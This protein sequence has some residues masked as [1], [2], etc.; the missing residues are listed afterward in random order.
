MQIELVRLVKG[1]PDI[2]ELIRIEH[3]PSVSR[4]VHSADN[5]FDYVTETE[6]VYYHKIMADGVTVGGIQGDINGDIIYLGVYVSERYRR[7]GIMEES[8]RKYFS[9]IPRCVNTI[10]VSIE[11]TNIPSLQLFR[12]LGFEAV[13]QEQVLIIFRFRL[14]EQNQI[15]TV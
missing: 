15:G 1:D 7:L 9:M 11:D 5:F 12:K 4:Y 6:G 3:E 14:N 10:E 2:G 8:L 13:G